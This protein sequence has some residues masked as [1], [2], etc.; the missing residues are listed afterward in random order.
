[1]EIV[2]KHGVDLQESGLWIQ[3]ELFSMPLRAMDNAMNNAQLALEE[4]VAELIRLVHEMGGSMEY[5]HGV[6]V[7][8]APLMAEE[9]GYGLDV[10]RQIKKT[11]D[12]NNIMN[13]GKL[14]L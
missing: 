5:T 12:P 14:A 10:M 1:M 2:K 3:P 4:T 9:H 8:L 13:P 7:K 11:L 6:G